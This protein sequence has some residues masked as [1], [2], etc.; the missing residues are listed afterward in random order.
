MMRVLTVAIPDDVNDQLRELAHREFRRPRDQA[1][2]LLIEAV[3]RAMAEP[4]AR[5][6]DA[7][8]PDRPVEPSVPMG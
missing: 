6:V 5:A 8:P 7:S 3:R 2:V 4:E 1:S